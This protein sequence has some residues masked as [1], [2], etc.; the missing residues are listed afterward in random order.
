MDNQNN[1]IPAKVHMLPLSTFK[2]N[3][4]SFYNRIIAFIEANGSSLESKFRSQYTEEQ[5]DALSELSKILGTGEFINR[6]RKE[7]DK[8]YDKYMAMSNRITELRKFIKDSNFASSDEE[9][10]NLEVQVAVLG[11]T[12]RTLMNQQ[13]LEFLTNTG[14]LPNYAFPESGVTLDATII[15]R[16]HMDDKAAKYKIEEISIQRSAS[17]ALREFAPGN[18]FYAQKYRMNISGLSTLN[19]NTGDKESLIK[20]RFCSK[21]DHIELDVKDHARECP[22]CGDPLF[23][24]T[25]NVHYFVRMDEVRS[26]DKKEDAVLDD[27]SDDRDSN[28]YVTSKHFIL[29][30][31][32]QASGLRT[33]PFGIEYCKSVDVIDINL[34]D[35]EQR[36][37]RDLDIN[38]HEHVPVKGFV[39]CKYCG[40]STSKSIELNVQEA[41]DL[42]YPFCKNKDKRYLDKPDEFFEEVYLYHKFHTE[43]IKILLPVQEVDTEETTDMFAAGI[44]LG[45]R[46]Y[47]EGNPDH[48]N[49]EKYKRY[50]DETHK[51]DRYVILYDTIPGGTGYLA[52]ISRPEEFEKILQNAWE[53]IHTCDCQNHGK[54]GC[55]HCIYTYN[56]NRIQDR[57]SRKRADELFRKILDYCHNEKNGASNWEDVKDLGNLSSDGGLEEPFASIKAIMRL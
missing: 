40:K 11:K 7:F 23:G 4:A 45:L 9:R 44:S 33:I 39:T 46:D 52:Q 12:R 43:A 29:D 21:C 35:S 36:D 2:T 13:V 48:I 57:L 50:N 14:L 37:V 56:N 53:R 26:S 32:V 5:K 1:Q 54:D 34:G 22:I 3:S 8:L 25:S 41:K 30:G 28:Y 51:F 38:E 24:T 20:M 27:K 47:F 16:P 15:H 6:I 17:F 42:H 55:Y 18:H 49:I 19:W 31:S 10:K